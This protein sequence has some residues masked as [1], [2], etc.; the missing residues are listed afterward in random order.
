M[1]SVWALLGL[2]LVLPADAARADW[3]SD[4]V[5]I[6]GFAKSEVY[7]R[8]PD[9]SGSSQ[10]KL[11]SWRSELNVETDVRLYEG[12]DL[13]VAFFGVVRPIYDSV[14]ELSSGTWGDH[15]RGASP[16]PVPPENRVLYDPVG[17][18]AGVAHDASEGESFVRDGNC[19]LGEFCLGNGDIG[20][21][22]SNE[23]ETSVIIDDV[24]FFGST[25]SPWQPRQGEGGVGGDA[26]GNTY[27]EYLGLGFLGNSAREVA[28]RARLTQALTPILGAAGAA[29]FAANAVQEG[30]AALEASLTPFGQM[31]PNGLAGRATRPL[32]TP[33]NFATGTLGDDRDFRQAPFDVNRREEPLA[34]DCLDNAHPWCIV[35]EAFFQIDYRDTSVRLGRQQ[36]VWGKTDA[37]RLQDIVNPVDLGYH[38]V[39]PELEDRRIPQLALDAIHSFGDVGPVQDFSLEL[40]W[41]FDRFI[42]LQ[43]GQCGEP[44][45]YTLA[46]QGRSDA[47]AHELFNFALGRVEEVEWKLGNTEPGMRA[48]FRLPE[49]SVSFSLSFFYGHQ[50]LPV[51]EFKN[52]YSTTNPNPAALLF[53][54]G[55]GLGSVVELLTG[56]NDTPWTTGIDPYDTSPGS[57]AQQANA[58]LIGTWQQTFNVNPPPLGCAGVTGEAL[59]TCANNFLPLALPWTASEYELRYP[60][61]WTLGASADYQISDWDTIVRIELA[62]DVDRGI[63]NTAKADGSDESDVF[64]AAVGID[65]PTYVPFLNPDRTAFLSFQTFF[66]HVMDYDGGGAAG[67]G[68][69]PY[70]TG[71]VTTFVNEH[72]WRNDSLI[73]RNF[74][75]YDWKADALLLGPSFKWV[76]NQHLTAQVGMNFLFGGSQRDHDLRQLCPGSAGGLDCL[77]DPT[78][79]NPGQ[80]Q[81]L[82]KDLAARSASPWWA[83]QGFAD[84]FQSRRDEVWIGFTY[85]F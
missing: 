84:R 44:Y 73:L 76:I 30:T 72:Y 47:S 42:P 69:V 10:L 11:S 53:L 55:L 34:F 49:P 18:G 77:G 20:S 6:H 33:F 68:M 56:T 60:R 7:G 78:T 13:R 14:Y 82:N 57:T 75:A 59:R 12:E 65:R 29:L 38:N 36:I 8:W 31:T 9:T 52:P 23:R 81:A 15:A 71:I 19:M 66:E 83:R 32:S 46:C 40:A 50:D 4:H 28:G 74:V 35:R 61:V 21:L 2:V 64:L 54:Q 41:N 43:F 79:W 70:E 51:A 3:W 62:Y 17:F 48:E 26:S 24:V 16:S 67:D 25:P 58:L 80:W 45:A 1:R 63:N 37:F 39:F 85:Q 5:E 27:L 22:F